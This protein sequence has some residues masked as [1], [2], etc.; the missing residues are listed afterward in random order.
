ME[1]I[2][3]VPGWE[4]HCLF[5]P[6]HGFSG[7]AAA[8]ESVADS[9]HAPSGLPIHSLYGETRT[10]RAEWLRDLDLVIVDLQ[11]LGVRCFTYAST[12][13]RTLIACANAEV[14]VLVLDRQVP[15]HGI[16]DGPELDPELSSFVGE[17][18]LPLVYGKTQG[19]LARFLQ[20]E[21]PDCEGVILDVLDAPSGAPPAWIPPS[22]ALVSRNSALC[23]P[24]TVWSE[25]VP[26]VWVDRG[27]EKSFCV[28]AMP[29]WPEDLLPDLRSFGYRS[30][31][32]HWTTPQGEWKGLQIHP[33]PH[34]PLFPVSAAFTFLQAC[35][36]AMGPERLFDREGARPEFFDQLAGTRSLRQALVSGKSPDFLR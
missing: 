27:G 20:A 22:P 9:V 10:P 33:L 21:D 2:G 4:L 23:Y 31:P 7:T 12:L 8:G 1:V 32:G 29:N 28:W 5:T 13:R 25:A 11:D 24:V 36:G 35:C 18:P 34:T 3:S 19:E 6:E 30:E 26:N 17:I 15:F 14:A 16:T